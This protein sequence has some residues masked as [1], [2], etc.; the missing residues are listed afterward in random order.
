MGKGVFITFEGGDG[1]GK[2]TH[3]K[4]LAK[5]LKAA[6]YDVVLIREPGGTSIGEKLRDILLD[7]K[8]TEL[9]PEAELLIYEASRAQI[10]EEVIKPAILAGKIVLCDRFFDSSV[11]YQGHGRGLDI[12]FIDKANHFATSGLAP[13]RTIL[14]RVDSGLTRKNRVRRRENSDRLDLES[15][16]FHKNIA[17]AFDEIAKD[18]PER[19]RVVETGGRHSDTAR[20]IIDEIDD[21]FDG[22]ANK[23]CDLDKMLATLDS[24]HTSTSDAASRTFSKTLSKTHAASCEHKSSKEDK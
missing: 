18:H 22:L 12:G 21:L 19:I 17:L 13:D 14:L 5:V 6:G 9:T 2:S 24:Q 15:D 20:A 4:F 10:T 8:N 23:V 11:V 7:P 3:I 16:E 1:S